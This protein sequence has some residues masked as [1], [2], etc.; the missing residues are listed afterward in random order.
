[1]YFPW[2]PALPS[3]SGLRRSSVALLFSDSEVPGD[4]ETTYWTGVVYEEFRWVLCDVSQYRGSS[5]SCCFSRRLRVCECGGTNAFCASSSQ[6]DDHVFLVTCRPCT[7]SALEA[8]A[9]GSPVFFSSVLVMLLVAQLPLLWMKT[10]ASPSDVYSSRRWTVA[11]CSTFLA[12]A[13][14]RAM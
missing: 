9:A 3:F 4:D 5:N 14:A 2:S 11:C 7:R 10:Q 1:M 6:C 13:A 12:P 8:A